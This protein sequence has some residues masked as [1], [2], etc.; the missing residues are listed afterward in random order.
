MTFRSG[1]RVTLKIDVD[2]NAPNSPPDIV[3]AGT[4]G[5][6]TAT[7][8]GDLSSV[9]IKLKGRRPVWLNVQLLERVP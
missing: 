6:V 5:I 8:K 4:E 1:M 3:K 9:A 2:L 7:G